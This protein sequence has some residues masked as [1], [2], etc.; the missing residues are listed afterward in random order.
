MKERRHR[1]QQSR[2][3][4][5]D[6]QTHTHTPG[7]PCPQSSHWSVNAVDNSI[8][9]KSSVV[10]DIRH[11]ILAVRLPYRM[12]CPY[13]HTSSRDIVWSAHFKPT[14]RIPQVGAPSLAR[15][16]SR[17]S[18][19]QKNFNIPSPIF[20]AHRFCPPRPGPSSYI[21]A[22]NN[23]LLSSTRLSYAFRQTGDCA[24]SFIHFSFYSVYFMC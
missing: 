13:S 2:H 17:T 20:H 16:I 18:N 11:L 5:L 10:H 6:T 22:R 7:P 4:S 14:P 9:H 24:S 21:S 19:V 8:P 23:C 1:Q 15:E 3:S 12:T